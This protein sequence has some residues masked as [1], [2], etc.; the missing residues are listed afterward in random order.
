MISI[1]VTGHRILA[2]IGKLQKGIDQALTRIERTFPGES[3]S[4]LSSL[5]EGADRLVVERIARVQPA[6]RLVVPLPL[7]VDEYQKDFS[8]DQSKQEFLHWFNLAHEVISPPVVAA[9]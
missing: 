6:A 3:W 8:S 7:P 4:V 1:G 9:R 2:E 5:A